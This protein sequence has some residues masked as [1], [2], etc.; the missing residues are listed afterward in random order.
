MS[1]INDRGEIIRDAPAPANHPA[2]TPGRTSSGGGGGCIP[3]WTVVI[4]VLCL[5]FFGGGSILTLLQNISSNNSTSDNSYQEPF[6]TNTSVPSFSPTKTPSVRPTKTPSPIA[7]NSSSN[8]TSQLIPIPSSYQ[9]PDLDKVELQ[10][11]AWGMVRKYDLSLRKEPIV[12]EVWDSNIIRVLHDGERIYV[13]GGPKCSHDGTWW[14]IKT[15]SDDVGWSREYLP[16][17]GR[18]LIR[19]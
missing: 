5:F 7:N 9:C 12:P 3:W 14:Q 1:K 18:L 4:V 8:L 19:K 13:V 17:K 15:E 11:G 10:I 16:S 2:P 6:S